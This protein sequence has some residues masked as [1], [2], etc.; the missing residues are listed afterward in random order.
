[1]NT[2]SK[3][4]PVSS[5]KFLTLIMLNA[6][7]FYKTYQ[8]VQL[9]VIM[10]D[11]ARRQPKKTDHTMVEALRNGG[12]TI[13]CSR[14]GLR[15]GLYL[16]LVITTAPSPILPKDSWIEIWTLLTWFCL[17]QPF[18]ERSF[19]CGYRYPSPSSKRGHAISQTNESAFDV[20]EEHRQRKRRR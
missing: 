4:S 1:M 9:R 2:P 20:E 12:A 5:R 16:Q 8:E 14:L 15:I 11:Q 6:S 13:H 19:L 18:R 10:D 17:Y 3:A 7:V